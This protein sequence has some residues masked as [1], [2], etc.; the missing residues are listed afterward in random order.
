MAKARSTKEHKLSNFLNIIKKKKV[1]FYL[2]KK[3]H[4]LLLDNNYA[5]LKF[6][7]YKTSLWNANEVLFFYFL[8]AL[9]L[10]FTNNKE[11]NKLN[12]IYKKIVFKSYGAKIAIDHNLSGRAIEIKKI[13]PEIKVIIYEVGF[14][15]PV[16]KLIPRIKNLYISSYKICDY[17][18]VFS[19]RELNIYKKLGLNNKTIIAGS[20]RNNGRPFKNQKK[21]YDIVYIS[22][23]LNS[24][25]N[26]E[27]IDKKNVFVHLEL[28]LKDHNKIE[29]FIIR[30]IHEYCEKYKKKYTIAV[31]GL[32][33]ERVGRDVGQEINFIEK[34]INKRFKIIREHGW[35]LTNQ[36]KLVINNCSTLGFELRSRGAN[37]LFLPLQTPIT[38]KYGIDKSKILKEKK[39][40]NICTSF[41]KEKI[42]KKINYLL[43]LHKKYKTSSHFKKQINIVRY[44]NKNSI[45]KG[46]VKKLLLAKNQN[47]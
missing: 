35:N 19:K 12:F 2:I 24:G 13:C 18:L 36:A 8:K 26:F 42:F 21:N 41:N 31:R 47:D 32:R 37:V 45:L 5:N 22:Q 44:D 11:K 3:S 38:K 34:I 43:K 25:S 15:E 10:Y 20:A 1:K 9:F 23:Y 29:R 33:Q 28:A 14:T 27:A 6:K 7:N 17:Y 30:T 40:V 39:A 4:I 46:L 16:N